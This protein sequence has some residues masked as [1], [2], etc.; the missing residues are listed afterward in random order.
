MA[1]DRIA[2]GVVGHSRFADRLGPGRAGAARGVAHYL[3]GVSGRIGRDDSGESAT[4]DFWQT[5]EFLRDARSNAFAAPY[6]DGY[7]IYRWGAIL[8]RDGPVL[9]VT[10]AATLWFVTVIGLCFAVVRWHLASRLLPWASSF[11][12][13]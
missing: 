6:P 3:A 10:T 7:G 13:V 9:G 12:R 4:R 11:C 5:S 8:L 1:R 2:I